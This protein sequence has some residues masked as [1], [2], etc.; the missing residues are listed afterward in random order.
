MLNPTLRYHPPDRLPDITAL[1]PRL[2]DGGPLNDD[3]A[4]WAVPLWDGEHWIRHYRDKRSGL[5]L[6]GISVDGMDLQ[7][8]VWMTCSVCSDVRVGLRK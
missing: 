5:T 7:A 8:V 6:C 2:D 1:S 4:K 3:I